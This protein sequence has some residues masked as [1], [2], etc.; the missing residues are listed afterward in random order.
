MCIRDSVSIAPVDELIVKTPGVPLDHIILL[1]VALLGV[2]L[3]DS[4]NPAS[5]LLRVVHPF[6]GDIADIPVTG[7]LIDDC[8]LRR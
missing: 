3:A 2:T 4:C 1:L 8:I 6:W 5:R 7:T